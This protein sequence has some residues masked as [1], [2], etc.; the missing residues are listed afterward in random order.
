MQSC[1]RCH[2]VHFTNRYCECPC[3]GT[4]NNT[5]TFRCGTGNNTGTVYVTPDTN[6]TFN[7]N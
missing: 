5:C 7:N 1:D 2:H 4:T 3:H 6:V